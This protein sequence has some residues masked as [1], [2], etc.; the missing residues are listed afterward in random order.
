MCCR[1]GGGFLSHPPSV[2]AVLG[3]WFQ[4]TGGSTGQMRRRSINIWNCRFVKALRAA[5]FVEWKREKKNMSARARKTKNALST[6]GGGS[7]VV[8][9]LKVVKPPSCCES[10]DQLIY[11]LEFVKALLKFQKG[12]SH[13]HFSFNIV[14]TAFYSLTPTHKCTIGQHRLVRWVFWLHGHALFTVLHFYVPF[15]FQM[16]A[17]LIYTKNPIEQHT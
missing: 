15:L 8:A 16:S 4:L 12:A 17:N 3:A 9:R 11:S 10:P 14:Y 6:R 1:P 5:Q 13:I 7:R 2:T